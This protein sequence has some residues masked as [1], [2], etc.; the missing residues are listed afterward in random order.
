MIPYP[1]SLDIPQYLTDAMAFLQ[2]NHDPATRNKLYHDSWEAL[3]Y[4]GGKYF[5]LESNQATPF[6]PFQFNFADRRHLV[7]TI[8]AHQ[9][10]MS[11]EAFDIEKL[12]S[13][14]IALAQKVIT[15]IITGQ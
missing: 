8:A 7:D 5:P 13:F 15:T 2:G 1:Q 12:Y 4:A 3:G 11:S 9:K 14:L 6:T 10:V